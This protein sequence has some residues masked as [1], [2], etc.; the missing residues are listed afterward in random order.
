MSS[1]SWHEVLQ[2]SQ[3]ALV[4]GREAALSDGIT[5]KWQG[6]VEV[7]G[8]CVL[9]GPGVGGRDMVGLAAEGSRGV[10]G[11]EH[12]LRFVGGREKLRE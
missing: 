2:S 12:G 10:G 4:V 8:G 3:Q 9:A 7:Y 6:Q 11:R 5:L 1:A